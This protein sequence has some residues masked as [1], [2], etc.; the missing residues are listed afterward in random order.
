[1]KFLLEIC[2]F[3]VSISFITSIKWN[4]DKSAERKVD[5]IMAKIMTYGNSGRK[6]PVN[7]QEMKVYCE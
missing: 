3:F 1:M 5:A 6:Y 7:R 2:L 4:C